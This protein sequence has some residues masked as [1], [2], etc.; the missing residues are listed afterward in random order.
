MELPSRGSADGP[1]RARTPGALAHTVATLWHLGFPLAAGWRTVLVS[2]RRREARQPLL[3][4]KKDGGSRAAGL[5]PAH[6]F[7]RLSQ[8]S[9][10]QVSVSRGPGRSGGK[11]WTGSRGDGCFGRWCGLT[12]RG[13]G[14]RS[15]ADGQTGAESRRGPHAGNPGAADAGR[16]SACSG[17]GSTLPCLLGLWTHGPRAAA[18]R[19]SLP[20]PVPLH[21]CGPSHRTCSLL[22]PFFSVGGNACSGTSMWS[23]P[24]RGF[25]SARGGGGLA[26]PVCGQSRPAVFC[27]SGRVGCS[28]PPTLRR[29]PPR[30]ALATGVRRLG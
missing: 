13:A 26:A 2:R 6:E 28:P 9:G 22:G 12:T 10:G 19:P 23:L 29:A 30:N 25:S 14:L 20:A 8:R 4:W 1:A 5:G 21:R 24:G 18:P 27:E 11:P 7:E 17:L 3:S 15:S 16:P